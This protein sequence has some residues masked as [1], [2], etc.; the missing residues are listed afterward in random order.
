MEEQAR[1]RSGDDRVSNSLETRLESG[2]SCVQGWSIC[3]GGHGS[4]GSPKST[5]RRAADGR[6]KARLKLFLTRRLHN[7]HS[8]RNPNT[9]DQA[10]ILSW[11]IWERCSHTE[12]N[13]KSVRPRTQQF[14][15][16]DPPFDVSGTVGSSETTSAA[17]AESFSQLLRA[18]VPRTLCDYHLPNA[19]S[20]L[21]CL[22]WGDNGNAEITVG[23]EANH[24]SGETDDL[25]T[26]DSCD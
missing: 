22:F 18:A 14:G 5:L 11:V 10:T 13:R 21:H 7:S 3:G 8:A 12:P 24:Q 6:H 17:V 2:K 20:T 25:Q 15:Q 16:I 26:T 9:F 23:T 1:V 4:R 19:P